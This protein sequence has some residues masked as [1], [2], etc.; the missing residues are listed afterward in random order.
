MDTIIGE[1][2]LILSI[3]LLTLFCHDR[4]SQRTPC[5]LTPSESCCAG[6]WVSEKDRID[7][8]R[9]RTAKVEETFPGKKCTIIHCHHIEIKFVFEESS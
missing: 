2:Q 5:I 7:R 4:H 3:C 6:P 8:L 9:T 1:L